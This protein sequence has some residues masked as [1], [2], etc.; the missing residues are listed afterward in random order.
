MASF[1]RRWFRR[2]LVALLTVSAVPFIAILTVLPWWAHDPLV[3]LPTLFHAVPGLLLALILRWRKV[4][5][6]AA[7]WSAVAVLGLNVAADVRPPR[8][9]PAP[10]PGQELRLLSFNIYQTRLADGE[11]PALV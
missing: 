2:L 6:R 9:S 3:Y 7:L 11:I 1:A 5:P 10:P 4:V 8:P